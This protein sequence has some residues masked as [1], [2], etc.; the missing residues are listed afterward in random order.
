MARVRLE[1]LPRH[2]DDDAPVRSWTLRVDGEDVG[3]LGGSRTETTVRLTATTTASG[4][5]AG[6]LSSA[7]GRLLGQAPWG[8]DVMYEIAPDDPLASVAPGAGFERV[9]P[10]WTRRAPRR[11][12]DGVERFLDASGRIDRYPQRDADRRALLAWVADRAFPGGE[13]LAEREV[14][15]RLAPFAPGGDVAVLR[16]HLVDHELLERTRSGSQYARASR[17]PTSP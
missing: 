3:V 5:A 17:S 9:G 12:A 4:E 10:T 8:P 14:N 1:M 2:G 11:R 15:E 13:V 16:R 6:A 7:L